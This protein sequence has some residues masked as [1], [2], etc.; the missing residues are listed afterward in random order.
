MKEEIKF[1]DK[2]PGKESGKH[3]KTKHICRSTN[4]PA[5]YDAGRFTSCPLCN[6]KPGDKEWKPTE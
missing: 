1:Q 6:L 4:S 2:G 3:D 5:S